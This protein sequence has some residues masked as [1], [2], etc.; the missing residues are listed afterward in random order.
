MHKMKC[1]LCDD[2]VF[3]GKPCLLC[4]GTKIYTWTDKEDREFRR[5]VN[6]INERDGRHDVR[7]C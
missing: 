1:P 6:V 3:Y 5:A 7:V 2:G 4:H